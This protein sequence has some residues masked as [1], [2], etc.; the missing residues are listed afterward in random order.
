MSQSGT[1]DDARALLAF[2][3]VKLFAILQVG[4][5]VVV[6]VVAAAV[7][8][9]IGGC[10]TTQSPSSHLNAGQLKLNSP[11]SSRERGRREKQ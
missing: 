7:V 5:V 11:Y 9:I 2:H 8:V 6:V 1:S 4:V 10:C 3:L